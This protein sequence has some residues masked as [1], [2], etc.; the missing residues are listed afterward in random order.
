MPKA[1]NRENAR[2]LP[3]ETNREAEI[4]SRLEEP[5]LDALAW[6]GIIDKLVEHD[7]SHWPRLS[8]SEINSVAQQFNFANDG[9]KEALGAIDDAY[10]G[11]EA[12]DAAAVVAEGAQEART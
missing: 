8:R 12:E 5:L 1:T 11:R 3:E 4:I 9:L 7:L 2:A 6:A 10:H